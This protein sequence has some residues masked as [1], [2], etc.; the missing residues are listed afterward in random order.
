MLKNKT[1]SMLSL[2]M[3]IVFSSIT[4]WFVH[5][6]VADIWLFLNDQGLLFK[7]RDVHY[8]S[9]SV[10]AITLYYSEM[11]AYKWIVKRYSKTFGNIVIEVYDNRVELH[12]ADLGHKNNLSYDFGKSVKYVASNYPDL[13][14]VIASWLMGDDRAKTLIF[15]TMARNNYHAN[16][17]VVS[18]AMSAYLTI[19]PILSSLV[20]FNFKPIVPILKTSI[21]KCEFVQA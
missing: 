1:K 12:I 10:I 3:T 19:M 20:R 9:I 4:F 2:L 5:H 7:V 21:K 6:H 17:Q 11:L 8:F 14:I 18:K 16:E 13:P 15:R